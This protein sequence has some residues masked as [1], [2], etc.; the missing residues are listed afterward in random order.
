MELL[1]KAVLQ[2]K[3]GKKSIPKQLADISMF[4]SCITQSLKSHGKKTK[5]CF[6]H[7]ISLLTSDCSIVF[8]HK[9]LYSSML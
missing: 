8:N 3:I 2:Q 1:K 6:Y 9:T 4:W 5:K 7:A